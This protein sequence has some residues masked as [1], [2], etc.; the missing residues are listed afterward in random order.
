MFR[1]LNGSSKNNKKF[2]EEL[3]AYSPFTATCVPDAK[4]R[5][6][7]LLFMSNEVEKTTITFERLEYWYC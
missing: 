6:E 2:L 1:F 7:T 4:N 5:K 3:I